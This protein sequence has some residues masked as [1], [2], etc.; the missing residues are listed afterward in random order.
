MNLLITFLLIA[1]STLS[2]AQERHTSFDP[3]THGF[4][5]E[6]TFT[7]DFI[8]EVDWRT[9]GLCG[10]M[11]YA[12][13][14][15]FL[16]GKP[17]PRQDYRPAVNS[18]LHDYIYDRQVHSIADNIDQWME[19][20]VN[21]LGARNSEFFKW[22]LEGKRGGRIDQLRASI[23]RGVPVPLGLFHADDHAGGDHQILA[24]GYKMGRYQGDLGTHQTDFEIYVYDPNKKNTRRILKADPGTEQWYYVDDHNKRWQTYFVD[25]KYR[26]HTPP[27]FAQ[28]SVHND[29]KV[30]V[31]RLEIT[32][33]GDDLRGGNDNVDIE[34]GVYGQNPQRFNNINQSRR[35]IDHYT[36]TI[37]LPLNRPVKRSDISHVKLL[38]HFSGGTGGDNWNVNQVTVKA[39]ENGQPHDMKTVSGEPWVRFTGQQR[40]AIIDLNGRAATTV[41]AH[42]PVIT[43][44][45]S[46]RCHNSLQN[47]V[48]WDYQGNKRWAQNNIDRLCGSVGTDQ[49]AQC[50]NQV[51]HHGVN[52]GGGTQW[53]WENALNLCAGSLNANRT[54]ACFKKAITQGNNWSTA[55]NSCQ[56]G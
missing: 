39:I 2:W 52:W 18:P 33:G 7:N 22:G 19:L 35:W 54:V 48:A 45:G 38:T 8:R 11:V 32:T 36:Q 25:R 30:H 12:A 15:H 37:E 9:N 44:S 5:F 14:D 23:D 6:N 29:G 10:G 56:R 41:R 47:K 28:A 17:I 51:M 26:S 42:I 16:A 24:I 53:Q 40:E 55:I 31:L 1:I 21:P 27:T 3:T 46:N 43:N 49:P 4:N 13:L 34:V 50:F 20:G